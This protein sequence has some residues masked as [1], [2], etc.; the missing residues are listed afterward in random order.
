MDVNYEITDVA[1]K[2]LDKAICY[3][4]LID[5]S[6][7]F[8]NDL[9]AQLDLIIK[10]PL[11]FQLRY[12]QVRII[13]LSQFNYSIHYSIYEGTIFILRIINQNQDF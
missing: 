9:M 13:T 1:Q 11:A 12:R 5:K 8:L 3:F 4:K 2:E 6:E 10:M 7:E